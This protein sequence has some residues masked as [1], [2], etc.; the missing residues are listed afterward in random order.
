[1]ESKGCKWSTCCKNKKK[2]PNN[3]IP[4]D[5]V[6]V[7]RLELP[8]SWPPVKHATNCA[9]PR[10][11]MN[12]FFKAFPPSAGRATNCATPRIIMN[13]FFKAFPPSAGRATN[14]ATTRIIMNYFFEAFPLSAGHATNCATPRAFL[15]SAAKVID[16]LKVKTFVL[17]IFSC[18]ICQWR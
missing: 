5:F 1:M 10:I 14:C 16:F 11:I 3:W 12:Y 17:R 13:Y 2:E 6:G 8:A 7:G 15:K 18:S 9:T 4:F